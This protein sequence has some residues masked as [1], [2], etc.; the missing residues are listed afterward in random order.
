MDKTEEN[1]F[2]V[3]EAMKRIEEINGKLAEE[4][5]ALDEALK[6]YKEGAILVKQCK[7]NLEGVRKELEIINADGN[8]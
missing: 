1:K 7:D 2:N 3:D 5:I 4:G 8:S 6:L